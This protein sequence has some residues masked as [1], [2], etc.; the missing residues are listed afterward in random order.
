MAT[1]CGYRLW[2]V[3]PMWPPM[4]LQVPSQSASQ[5]PSQSLQ[6]SRPSQCRCSSEALTIA[7]GPQLSLIVAASPP[8]PRSRCSPQTTT[9]RVR[10]RCGGFTD[11]ATWRRRQTGEPAGSGSPGQ[12][13]TNTRARRRRDVFAAG[14]GF[15]TEGERTPR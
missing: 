7:A 3:A 1:V 13:A 5:A 12:G 2:L 6:P 14:G 10:S 8:G 9:R 4:W 15:T 11:R